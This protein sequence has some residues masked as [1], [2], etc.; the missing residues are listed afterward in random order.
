MGLRGV[1][2]VVLALGVVDDF[3]GTV[4]FAVIDLGIQLVIDL[5]DTLSVGRQ[6]V[7]RAGVHLGVTVQIGVPEIG[8]AVG[9]DHFSRPAQLVPECSHARAVNV[10]TD[11]DEPSAEQHVR[12]IGQRP[13]KL[14]GRAFARLPKSFDHAVA[15]RPEHGRLHHPVQPRDAPRHRRGQQAQD[16][17]PDGQHGLF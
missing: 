17:L 13:G 16:F 14:I 6:A 2:H 10:A 12:C 9:I 7:Q 4:Y 1:H 8:F 3:H 11:P 15:Q 5:I